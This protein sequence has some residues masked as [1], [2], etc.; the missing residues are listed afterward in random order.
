MWLL[1]YWRRTCFS[2]PPTF[3]YCYKI[4]GWPQ[5]FLPRK[6]EIVDW[7]STYL[8]SAVSGLFIPIC[9][10]TS[11]IICIVPSWFSEIGARVIW[12]SLKS[13][14]I[15]TTMCQTWIGMS[16]RAK[17]FPETVSST[18]ICTR[19]GEKSNEYIMLLFCTEKIFLSNNLGERYRV[20][21]RIVTD[22]ELTE[23]VVDCN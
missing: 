19:S 3:L 17:K 20:K 18:W 15:S 8:E 21:T 23:K 14:R 11:F 6:Q 10:D 22:L 5:L 13:F 4:F 2:K 16:N 7:S 12:C 9:S 1:Y